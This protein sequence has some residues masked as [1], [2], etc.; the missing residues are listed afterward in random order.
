MSSFLKKLSKIDS[1]TKYSVYGWIR[2]M[3]KRLDIQHVPL[4]ITSICIL[5]YHQ[6]EIFDIVGDGFKLS[7]DKKCITKC[8]NNHGEKVYGFIQVPSNQSCIHQW[9]LKLNLSGS[10]CVNVIGI[11]SENNPSTNSVISDMNCHRY[12]LWMD[13]KLNTI[14]CG[15]SQFAFC[16]EYCDR[17]DGD[18]TVSI[19]LDLKLNH[20]RFV[21]NGED[22]GV[23]YDDIAVG[24]DIEY[25]LFI[26]LYEKSNIVQIL[27]FRQL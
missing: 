23:A 27:N 17:L 25:R 2:E 14:T 1:R 19:V 24:S 9:D 16:R 4:M 13:G 11:S 7:L 18:E 21:I 10:S 6:D 20:I 26:G 5:Y 15:T 8:N 22:N 12:P 3:E